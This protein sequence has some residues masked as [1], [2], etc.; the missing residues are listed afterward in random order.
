MSEN[1]SLSPADVQR[2]LSDRSAEARA[3]TVEK[4]AGNLVE[5]QFSDTERAEAEAIFRALAGDAEILVRQT[6]AD[7]LKNLPDLPHDIALTLASDIADVATPM[8]TFSEAL[9][10]EDL[11]EI[12]N[13]QPDS[14]QEAIAA[15]KVV[16]E[17]VS[18]KLADTGNVNVVAKLMENDGAQISEKTFEK[19]LDKY[20]DNEKVNAPM[21]Q[22][23]ELPLTVTERLVTLVSDKL[24]EHLVSHH[25]MSPGVATDLILASREKTMIGLLKGGTSSED[26]KGLIDQLHENGRLTPTIILRALCVGDID[27]FETAL[28]KGSGISVS[29]VHLLVN[30]AGGE[31]LKQL[32]KKCDIPAG[33]VEMMRVAVEVVNELEYDGTPGDRERFRNHV[34]QRVLTHFEDRFDVENVDYLISKIG[35]GSTGTTEA[36]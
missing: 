14:H 5:H 26:L 17:A 30:D 32:C 3:K 29:N 12:I 13:S 25:E 16:S 8:L 28:S 7:T 22:R 35:E 9:S 4:I 20:G 33:L 24:R 31:G 27:F 2:L 1:G 6:L 36:A 19:V 18:D 15:R 10:D 21:A 34:I 11:F 23:A